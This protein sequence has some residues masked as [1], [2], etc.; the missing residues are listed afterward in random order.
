MSS[1]K[2]QISGK[3]S[4]FQNIAMPMERAE[5]LA[6]LRSLRLGYSL[7]IYTWSVLIK[8]YL[9]GYVIYWLCIG[10]TYKAG[11]SRAI[12]QSL[13]ALTSA[14]SDGNTLAAESEATSHGGSAELVPVRDVAPAAVAAPDADEA[15][16]S[17]AGLYIKG[18]QHHGSMTFIVDFDG[19][20]GSGRDPATPLSKC[21]PAWL[22]RRS[23]QYRTEREDQDEDHD[24]EVH[25]S[26]NQSKRHACI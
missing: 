9:P 5:V 16:T 17:E 10:M 3:D 25:H 1:V 26:F 4:R 19:S 7:L 22:R 23:V 12:S 20:G 18:A 15:H 24:S 11:E 8:M 21:L 6:N 13:S 2:L 14:S